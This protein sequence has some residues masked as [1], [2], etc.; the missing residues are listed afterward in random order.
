MSA[1]RL[2]DESSDISHPLSYPGIKAGCNEV[3]GAEDTTG[4]CGRSQ[5]TSVVTV[6]MQESAIPPTCLTSEG[7]LTI[8]SKP[9]LRF[10][11]RLKVPLVR[12]DIT[13]YVL[14]SGCLAS[15]VPCKRT[16]GPLSQGTPHQF[17]DWQ[18]I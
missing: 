2:V 14:H 18:L 15:R 8:T 4:S 17:V 1:L 12:Q 6:V 10:R 9:G 13:L 11:L 3:G 7:Q 16:R 5:K